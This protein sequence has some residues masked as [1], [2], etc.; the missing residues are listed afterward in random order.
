MFPFYDFTILFVL[1]SNFYPI[2]QN[3]PLFIVLTQS[4]RFFLLQVMFMAWVIWQPSRHGAAVVHQKHLQ[5]GCSMVSSAL[6]ITASANGKSLFHQLLIYYG[7]WF[8]MKDLNYNAEGVEW[9]GRVVFCL[10]RNRIEKYFIQIWGQFR[11]IRSKYV[12]IL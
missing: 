6:L 8:N 2:S 10:N 5:V 1:A 7:P 12:I 3:Q 11:L 4:I 9:H